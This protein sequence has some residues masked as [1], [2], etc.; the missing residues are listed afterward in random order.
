[1]ARKK[2]ACPFEN[3][4]N[5]IT[6]D[7]EDILCGNSN[8]HLFA[9]S[10][11]VIEQLKDR[12][13]T[14]YDFMDDYVYQAFET[15][16]ALPRT[17]GVKRPQTR[18][19]K[20]AKDNQRDRIARQL[21]GD[22]SPPVDDDHETEPSR[23]VVKFD[24]ET[25]ENEKPKQRRPR[26]NGK[27]NEKMVDERPLASSVD[28]EEDDV[29]FVCMT[30]GHDNDTV[31]NFVQGSDVAGAIVDDGKEMSDKES[32][33]MSDVAPDD[34]DQL[35]SE[36]SGTEDNDAME[37]EASGKPKKKP[38]KKGG[39]A[40]KRKKKGRVVRKAADDKEESSTAD[41]NR[42]QADLPAAEEEAERVVLSG[43]TMTENKEESIVATTVGDDDTES[44]VKETEM[45]VDE[46]EKDSE[47]LAT[48]N[49][50]IERDQEEDLKQ[51]PTSSSPH[52]IVVEEDPDSRPVATPPK[53]NA[54]PSKDN[55][56]QIVDPI[57][58]TEFKT[59]PEY[60]DESPPASLPESAALSSP[61][62]AKEMTDTTAAAEES[63]T[64]DD[65]D[66][67]DVTTTAAEAAAEST[68]IY[69]TDQTSD[70]VAET[71]LD[72][73]GHSVRE[74]ENGV[75][76]WEEM[77]DGETV[78]EAAEAPPIYTNDQMSD[79]A[80]EDEAS[81]DHVGYSVS[82]EE[83]GIEQWEEEEEATNDQ[84]EELNSNSEDDDA[85][86]PMPRPL[87]GRQDGAVGSNATAS[88]CPIRN[89]VTSVKTFI[90]HS[91]GT[92]TPKDQKRKKMRDENKKR[93]S[94]RV[95]R[96]REESRKKAEEQKR[97][98][99]ERR[100]QVKERQA[101]L[102]KQR[103]E[104][105]KTKAVEKKKLCE[106]RCERV[107]HQREMQEGMKK[108]DL[109]RKMHDAETRRRQE[110]EMR[111]RQWLKQEEARQFADQVMRK[112]KAVEDEERARKAEEQRRR[113][114]KLRK[115][116][117]ER[118]AKMKAEAEARL[119][120]KAD[121]DAELKREL[122]LV[123]KNAEEN[124]SLMSSLL[125]KPTSTKPMIQQKVAALGF[126]HTPASSSLTK[127]P[128]SPLGPYVSSMKSR[129]EAGE[130]LSPLV[131]SGE[132]A[133]R[134]TFVI[135]KAPMQQLTTPKSSA[136]SSYDMTPAHPLDDYGIDD[137][138][139]SDDTDDEDAP[140]KPVPAWASGDQLKGAL[141]R[142]CALPVDA[143][144][145]FPDSDVTMS[146]DLLKMFAS[147]GRI[148]KRYVK[149]TSSA[150]WN[151]PP[152]RRQRCDRLV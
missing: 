126:A 3:V 107:K 56:D 135:P 129:F 36:K 115:E 148:R 46:M 48:E 47:L 20:K 137:Y 75:E 69:A 90:D 134:G 105:K 70:N 152:F 21:F 99:E 49:E 19:R 91:G 94:E 53:E 111:H 27:K 93:P 133:R 139:S 1:M 9:M 120:Q 140:A 59:P 11:D 54:T 35:A 83:N 145:V 79:V 14:H 92:G 118:E 61:Q 131:E 41:E 97:R 7:I 65:D 89:L 52:E 149:R 77:T 150:Q 81:I 57:P 67:D 74:D 103:L 112:R 82:E 42:A 4:P 39:R 28:E 51:S 60:F 98:Q 127:T 40:P 96:L 34:A 84:Y 22:N 119:K 38:K 68:P 151:T 123:R 141:R 80:E 113:E 124:S 117:E 18:S 144:D 15:R 76:Q 23:K 78:P 142:Q 13:E 30:T 45:K 125:H 104:K 25:K 114:E 110:E 58:S 106:Q 50:H 72:S 24:D 66:D 109:Q 32:L 37:E 100:K 146:C 63:M 17:P 116:K 122:D 26:K 101:A 85:V 55:V 130:G 128:K 147:N 10:L 71:C 102:E 73:R 95:R 108:M 138:C 64:D 44:I 6:D 121:R 16:K 31:E 2:G 136:S 8:A 62:L 87:L 5:G 43:G 33:K 29:V 132:G 143:D 88:G 86:F 12:W